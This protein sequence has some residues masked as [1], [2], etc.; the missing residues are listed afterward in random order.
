MRGIILAG[1]SG[2]RLYP[3]TLGASK[4][5]LPVYDKPLIYYPLSTLIMAGIRDIQVITTAAD[6][7]AFHRLLGDG[8]HFGV[9]LTYAVQDRPDGLAQ[10]YLIGREFVGGQTSCLVIGDNNTIREFCTINTGTMQGGGVTVVG[11]HNWIMAYVHI[12]HDCRLGHN[13]V[14][15]N[16]VQLA[17][18]VT[19]GNW[20]ILGGLTGVHQF[21]QIGDHSMTAFQTKLTQDLPPYVMGAGY[22]ASASGINTEGLKRRGFSAQTITAIKRAYKILYRQGLSLE[23]AKLAIAHLQAEAK[24]DEIIQ[25]LKILQSFLNQVN[26]GIVR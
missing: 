11:H 3:I 5:L 12:A 1:G 23:E 2:T 25:A 7:P 26:R 6:A 14:I 18:H 20:V 10:A 21:I 17:G 15:A 4:Q 19:I 8:S 9:N 13:N 22:P 24:E 16:S